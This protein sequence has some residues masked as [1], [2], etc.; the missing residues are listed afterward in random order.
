MIDFLKAEETFRHYLKN[1]N[2]SKGP[3]RLKI[4][5]TYGVVDCSEFVSKD[6]DLDRQDI[7]LAKVIALLHDIGR[8]EQAESFSDY[9]DY[10]T[11]DHAELGVEILKNNDFIRDFIEDDSF[12]EIIFEAIS[13]HNKLQIE[14]GLKSQ[15]LLHC[16][17]IRDADKMD[18]FRVK[19][20]DSFEDIF[21]SSREKLENSIITDKIFN[22]FMSSKLIVT[23]ERETDMDCWVSYIAFL[24]DF[25]FI[26]PFKFIKDNSYISKLVD[27]IDYKNKETE[28]RMEKIREH[29]QEFVDK[30]LQNAGRGS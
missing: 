12:D 3:I 29:A 11:T 28:V 21:G 1:F 16:K 18:N 24:F 2:T 8:F 26:A 15:K 14:S 23:S 4:I 9:R 25:N 22:D 6:L 30:K 20:N 10:K 27:R 19:A 17:I 5:H 13:N 7:Q